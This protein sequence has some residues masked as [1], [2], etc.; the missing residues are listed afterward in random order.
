MAVTK[1]TR[2]R[3]A[4]AA[5]KYVTE[6]QQ[7]NR[8]SGTERVL[9][10]GGVNVDPEYAMWSMEDTRRAFGK[11]GGNR[12][13]AYRVIQ[14]FGL[15]ELNP[16]NEDDAE[17]ANQMGRELARE[18]YPNH[19]AVVVTQ[20]DGDGGKLHNHIV[21]NAVSF[22]D[23]R[24]LRGDVTQWQTVSEASDR[25]IER[26]GLVPLGREGAGNRRTMGERKRD[27]RG[28]YV[29]K[30]DL[31]E[32]IMLGLSDGDS[33][34]QEKFVKH[35]SEEHGVEVRFRGKTGVSYSFKDDEDKS[36]IARGKSLGSDFQFESLHAMLER[37]AKRAEEQAKLDAEQALLDA[38]AKRKVEEAE[39]ERE[40]MRKRL[41]GVTPEKAA[42]FLKDERYLD[43]FIEV[44]PELQG[45]PMNS[46]LG[47]AKGEPH[48]DATI[49]R[50]VR[51]ELDLE[52]KARLQERLNEGI[53]MDESPER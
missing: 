20:A 4:N 11:D 45:T 18:L 8:V 47:R 52:D 53:Q 40:R 49:A 15:N 14:S 46:V 43:R 3:N 38:E 35:M 50:R 36:R 31:K 5:V 24:S 1:I 26:H 30:D 7:K 33:I 34:S 10:A 13:Q 19:E 37:N 48:T 29:W 44:E 16:L 9:V 12:V 41:E 27:A 28:E 42:R 21:V 17:L 23:G 32:R 6:E 51:H 22:V 39:A 2:T 25:I